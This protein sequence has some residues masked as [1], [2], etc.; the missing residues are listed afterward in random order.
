MIEVFVAN[1]LKKKMTALTKVNLINC[2]RHSKLF[3]AFDQE[4]E[5]FVMLWPL[6]DLYDL[7]QIPLQKNRQIMRK[8]ISQQSKD[9]LKVDRHRYPSEESTTE[10]S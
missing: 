7:L 4:S 5:T 2:Y 6:A 1:R 10:R 8:R 9:H 3:A